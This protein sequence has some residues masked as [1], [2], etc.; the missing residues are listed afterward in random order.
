MAHFP[1]TF[2]EVAEEEEEDKK[3]RTS[4]RAESKTMGT[5]GL[6]RHYQGADPG[7]SPGHSPSAEQH[8]PGGI[9]ELLLASSAM[10]VSF[11]LNW[12]DFYSHPVPASPL[13]VGCV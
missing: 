1:K 11:L 8:W 7:P 5:K 13:L 12:S 6:G 9:S 10:N 2:S 4:Q 3:G